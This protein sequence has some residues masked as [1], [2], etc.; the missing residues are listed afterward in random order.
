MQRDTKY[1]NTLL[2]SSY[3]SSSVMSLPCTFLVRQTPESIFHKVFV[4]FRNISTLKYFQTVEFRTLKLSRYFHTHKHVLI[5]IF[6]DPPVF[7]FTL[8]TNFDVLLT[9]HLSVFISVISQLG[10]QNF[11]FTISLFHASICFE[12]MCS[13]SGCQNCITQPLVSSHL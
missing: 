8:K 6:L 10:A 4:K 3:S 5:S 2:L 11:C 1:A 9:V 13:S 7:I 12:Y